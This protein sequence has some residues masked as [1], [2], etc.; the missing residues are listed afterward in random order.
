MQSIDSYMCVGEAGDKL[1]ATDL[2]WGLCVGAFHNQGQHFCGC[3]LK[4]VQFLS[5]ALLDDHGRAAREIC[6]RGRQLHVHKQHPMLRGVASSSRSPP[7][8]TSP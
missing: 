5:T 2:L 1:G 8:A 7:F 4:V 6:G 3:V